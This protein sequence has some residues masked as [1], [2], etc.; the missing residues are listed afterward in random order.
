[1]IPLIVFLALFLLLLAALALASI[2]LFAVKGPDGGVTAPGCLAG[3]ATGAALG[4]IGLV[5]VVAFCVGVGAIST[6]NAV[7]NGPIESV[8]VWVDPQ[9]SAHHD[10]ERPLHVVVEWSGHSEPDEE[11]LDLVHK[12]FENDDINIQVDYT[13]NDAGEEIS[14]ADLALGVGDEDL[15]DLEDALRDAFDGASLSNG[16]QIR[17]RGTHR[18]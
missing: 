15:E 2:K 14:V 7:K 17:L 18:D 12:V 13:T 4:F 5:G 6:V 8:G 16:I 10:P 3:C 9:R 11:L 1:V